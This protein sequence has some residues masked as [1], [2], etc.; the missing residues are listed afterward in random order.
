MQVQIEAG[1]FVDLW[2]YFLELDNRTPEEEVL[3]RE[4]DQ[5]V[6]KIIARS[7]YSKYKRTATPEERDAARLEYLKHKETFGL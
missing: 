4:L 2:R 3:F 7:L 1:V 6:N 5:K